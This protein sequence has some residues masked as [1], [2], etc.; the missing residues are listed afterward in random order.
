MRLLCYNYFFAKNVCYFIFSPIAGNYIFRFSSSGCYFVRFYVYSKSA[1]CLQPH[2][3]LGLSWW[4]FGARWSF[5]YIR[6]GWNAFFFF[7][8]FFWYVWFLFSK[9]ELLLFSLARKWLF[10]FL[11]SCM[12]DSCSVNGDEFMHYAQAVSLME[13]GRKNLLYFN[14]L[15]LFCCTTSPC[16]MLV[17]PRI[18]T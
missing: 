10:F 4:Y 16:S 6:W 2:K 7:F 15:W 13:Y 14:Y 9:M 8:P 5:F 17:A 18:F 1:S 12:C 11:F 3:P